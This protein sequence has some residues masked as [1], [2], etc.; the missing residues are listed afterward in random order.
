MAIEDEVD[1]IVRA[2]LMKSMD[3][4]ESGPETSALM[5]LAHRI[6]NLIHHRRAVLAA[7]ASV[8]GGAG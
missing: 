1:T 6:D 2:H 8:A 4:D 7:K 3:S 5:S